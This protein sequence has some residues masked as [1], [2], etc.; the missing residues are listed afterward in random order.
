MNLGSRAPAN[1]LFSLKRC[2]RHFMEIPPRQ[3]RT[4]RISR[5][6]CAYLAVWCALIARCYAQSDS[7]ATLGPII[8]DP[9]AGEQSADTSEPFIPVP[10]IGPQLPEPSDF[11]QVPPAGRPPG[12]PAPS[13]G[14]PEFYD[15]VWDY[16]TEPNGAPSKK[17]TMP[18]DYWVISTRNCP[19]TGSPCTADQNTQFYY[20]GP[21]GKGGLRNPA[22]FYNTLRPDVPVCILVHGSLVSWDHM[23]ADGHQTYEWLKKAQPN[24]PFR[25]VLLTWPSERPLLLVA[26]IDFTMLGR[27]SSYNGLYL[28]RVLSKMPSTTSVSMIGHSHGA[29]LVV[30]A[31]HLA[32]GGDVHGY[33]L[34]NRTTPWPRMRAMTAAAA[35][36]HHW[37]DPGERYGHALDNVESMVNLRNRNDFALRLYLLQLPVSAESLGRVG[38]NSRDQQLLG[39]NY[40]KVR[41]VEVSPILG[42]RHVWPWF[43]SQPGLAKTL[44]PYLFFQEDV[45]PSLVLKPNRRRWPGSPP[46]QIITEIPKEKPTRTSD[47]SAATLVRG[48]APERRVALPDRETELSSESGRATVSPSAVRVFG[49]PQSKAQRKK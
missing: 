39:A 26:P 40:T 28:G 27:R 19:Q 38:F 15:P 13:S 41:D 47:A 4:C 23:L 45:P 44:S 33:R 37:L 3:V 24:T 21:T 6:I 29:R 46:A 8:V 43:Y 32:G 12:Q 36:D 10:Q 30:S 11:P 35:L 17:A 42:A 22:D 14:A 48:V 7:P 34:E 9:I 31:M 49:S 20:Y 1:L 25:M 16:A 2:H 5:R 18:P